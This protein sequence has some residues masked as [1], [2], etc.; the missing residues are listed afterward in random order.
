MLSG[1]L[2]LPLAALPIPFLLLLLA[3]VAVSCATAPISPEVM[4]Q[5]NQE[6]GMP[7][8]A[9]DPEAYRGQ[10]VLLGGRIIQTRNLSG[11]TEI[12]VLQTPLE[13]G[14]RPQGGDVSQGRFLARLPDYADPAV[15]APGRLITVAG[16][17]AGAE[18]RPLGEVEY[19]YPT[20]DALDVHL[21]PGR[22][23]DGYPNFFFSIG[24]GTVF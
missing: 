10:V 1:A 20:L 4:G 3:L 16:R 23:R 9:A 12:E 7:Q 22:E 14:Q 11:V 24:V 21:W 5:V 2:R 15:Y 18:F 6:I 13:N 8:L 19:S 17:V